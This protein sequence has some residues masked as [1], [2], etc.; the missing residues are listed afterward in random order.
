MA[1]AKIRRPE[2]KRQNLGKKSLRI[3]ENRKKLFEKRVL[4]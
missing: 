4:F 3:G 2:S 1:G